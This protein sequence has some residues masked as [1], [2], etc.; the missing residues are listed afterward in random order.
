MRNSLLRASTYD[1]C[2]RV[3][4]NHK[5]VLIHVRLRIH[6]VLRIRHSCFAGRGLI[7]AIITDCSSFDVPN[8]ELH[9]RCAAFRGKR[10]K[11][12]KE[13]SNKWVILAEIILYHFIFYRVTSRLIRDL[14]ISRVLYSLLLR[15][16]VIRE[17]NLGLEELEEF[18]RGR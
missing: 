15:S 3:W 5:D 17:K 8:V 18:G 12:D 16:W 1:S 11:R 14:F 2:Q 9:S 7:A 13:T 4:R 10:E 6:L